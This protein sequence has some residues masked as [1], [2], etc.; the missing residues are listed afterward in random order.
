MEVEYSLRQHFVI[1]ELPTACGRELYRTYEITNFPDVGTVA[2][3]SQ[4]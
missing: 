1:C 2:P 3:I 4:P